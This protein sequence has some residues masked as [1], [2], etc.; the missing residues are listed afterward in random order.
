MFP[1]SGEQRRTKKQWR[2]A[3]AAEERRA[4][5]KLQKQQSSGNEVIS[6]DQVQ[7]AVLENQYQR[8]HSMLPDFREKLKRAITRNSM[9]EVTQEVQAAMRQVP[10][11]PQKRDVPWLTAKEQDA[12]SDLSLTEEIEKFAEYVGVS[13]YR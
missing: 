8:A 13:K 1:P 10:S 5:I 9:G 4:R 6:T 7:E 12:T 3:M 2:V 11:C